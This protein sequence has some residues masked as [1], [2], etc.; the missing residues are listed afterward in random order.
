MPKL[1]EEDFIEPNNLPS[2]NQS[3]YGPPPIGMGG[4]YGADTSQKINP[5]QAGDN[6]AQNAQVLVPNTNEDFINRKWRPMMGWM[7]MAVCITDFVIFPVLWSVIQVVGGGEVKSQWDPL[8]LKGAGLFHI[9]MGA[10]LGI[11]VYGRTQEKRDG[12]NAAAGPSIT[13]TA[14]K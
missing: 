12:V 7:Y 14:N 3:K 1:D 6:A 5:T 4:G 10:V 11:A 8:T 2:I 9:A 13:T